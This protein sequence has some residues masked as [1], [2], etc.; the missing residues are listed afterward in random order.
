MKNMLLA[1]CASIALTMAAAA[2]SADDG[3]YY[4]NG[5][6]DNGNYGNDG[7]GQGIVSPP[8]V[9]SVVESNNFQVI[10]QPVLSGRFYQVKAIAPNGKK[11]KVYVDAFSGRIAKVKS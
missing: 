9:V 7:Y 11:V 5:Y 10:S 1:A 2:A 8:A 3:R 6:G 4:D